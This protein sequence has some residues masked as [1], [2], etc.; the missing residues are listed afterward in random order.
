MLSTSLIGGEAEAS[1]EYLRLIIKNSTQ[2]TQRK[3]IRYTIEDIKTA[4]YERLEESRSIQECLEKEGMISLFSQLRFFLPYFSKMPGFPESFLFLQETQHSVSNGRT[5]IEMLLN[6]QNLELLNV[7]AT[8]IEQNPILADSLFQSSRPTQESRR[9]QDA[10]A[11][12]M[13]MNK[14]KSSIRFINFND[15]LVFLLYQNCVFYDFRT[16][17]KVMEMTYDREQFFLEDIIENSSTTMLERFCSCLQAVGQAELSDFFQNKTSQYLLFSHAFPSM[18]HNYKL[19]AKQL[20]LS[21]EL[22]HLLQ[23]AGIIAQCEF[24]TINQIILF[25]QNSMIASWP[26]MD[27][28][29]DAG[30]DSFIDAGAIDL[31]TILIKYLPTEKERQLKKALEKTDQ[32]HIYKLIR[33]EYTAEELNRVARINRKCKDNYGLLREELQLSSTLLNKLLQEKIIRECQ[34][35]TLSAIQDNSAQHEYFL[36]IANKWSPE[37]WESLFALWIQ[38]DLMQRPL[39]DN[40]FDRQSILELADKLMHARLTELAYCIAIGIYEPELWV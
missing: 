12:F 25:Q 35:N 31:F 1:Y 11:P 3:Q 22:L 8:A 5:F 2:A 20:D 13:L 14:I 38:D 16:L 32:L 28:F 17:Q 27:S 29:I 18:T 33:N 19:L 9:N 34:K 40:M 37:K 39:I 10:Q 36:K 23:K 6:S 30:M 24:Q 4:L 15:D 26:E 21:S 7:F